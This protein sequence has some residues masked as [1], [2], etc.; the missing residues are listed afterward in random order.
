VEFALAS[1]GRQARRGCCPEHAVGPPG[2]AV[3]RRQEIEGPAVDVRDGRPA[4]DHRA[5]DGIA[6][7]DP[8]TEPRHLS[9]RRSRRSERT[10]E[11][12]LIRP[13]APEGA[14]PWRR[15]PIGHVCPASAAPTLCTEQMAVGRASASG[16]GAAQEHA[17]GPIGAGVAGREEIEGPAVDVRDGRQARDHRAVDGIADGEGTDRPA[18]GQRM[19]G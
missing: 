7:G 11:T 15:A 19:A 2:A 13:G 18:V 9:S 10:E 6:D 12:R 1:A 5:V 17:V 4:R 8:A 16:E 3:A 14:N